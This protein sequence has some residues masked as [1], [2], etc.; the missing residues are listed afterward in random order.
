MA[1]NAK[2]KR[3]PTKWYPRKITRHSGYTCFE[4]V[5]AGNMDMLGYIYINNATL[6][7]SGGSTATITDDTSI[8]TITA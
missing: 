1:W 8:V 7:G 4:I 5:P 2:I 6:V 3:T